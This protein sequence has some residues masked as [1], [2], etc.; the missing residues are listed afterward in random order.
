L[1][2]DGYKRVIFNHGVREPCYGVKI[3][4]LK[5]IQK[6]VKMDYPLA[7]DLFDTG[8]YDAQYLAGLIA[9]DAKMTA[10]D[11]Q[12]WVSSPNCAAIAGTTVAWVAAGSPHGA[13]AALKWIDS[14][15]E[16]EALAGWATLSSLVAITEDSDL[17]LPLLKR[18]LQR[19]EK[20]MLQ[21]PDR[22]RYQ[23]NGFVIAVGCYVA[24][25][26]DAAIGA[27]TRLGQITCDMGNT[28]CQVPFAPDY[29]RKVQ[30]RGTIGKK[31]KSA[32][33]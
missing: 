21:A 32:K 16:V 27:G 9:D 4:E 17:D 25:L 23:M 5:K 10:K 28:A 3:E 26:T 19:A 6:R 13:A 29:I 22:V 30:A 18:L 33:C 8:V 7:L 14:K 20:S 12:R 2:T 24:A 15:N 11:L 1:G 31:R